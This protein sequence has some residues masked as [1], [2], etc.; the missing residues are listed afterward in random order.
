LDTLDYKKIED[1]FNVRLPNSFIEWHK[2]YYL[3]DGDCSLL[4]LPF[5]NPLQPLQEVKNNLDWYIAKQLIPQKIYPFATEGND[6]G[7][8]VFDGRIEV[9]NNEFQIRVYDQDFGGNL[10]GLGEV[11]FSSFSKLLECLTHY[12]LELKARKSFEILPDFFRID[13]DGAGKTGIDYWLSWA[14]MQ[15]ANFQEFGV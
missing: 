14:A 8:L 15:R 5:S 13:P 3:L 9:A 2:S 11:V 1:Q 12:M 4:R 10:E 7:P 6:G